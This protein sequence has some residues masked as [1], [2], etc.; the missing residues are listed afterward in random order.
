MRHVADI[1]GVPFAPILPEPPPPCAGCNGV[2]IP[3]I[4]HRV[5]LTPD[6]P[7]PEQ[8]LV[9][10]ESWKRFHTHWEHKLWTI[11]NLPPLRNQAIFDVSQNFSLQSDI[12]RYEILSIYGGVYLDTDMECLAAI[13]PLICGHSAFAG[14]EDD[15]HVGN[16]ILGCT[17]GHPFMQGMVDGLAQSIRE[18][19]GES[20]VETTGPRYLQRMAQGRTDISLFPARF[21]Y[22]LHAS[23]RLDPPASYPGAYAVHHWSHSWFG[24]PNL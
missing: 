24:L 21:F 14:W 17:A 6:R 11:N 16:A 20:P 5:W 3:K 1:L 23:K 4:F 8:Y 19:P 9:W 10:A 12:V 18:R 2:C 15:W 22:P 7:M 13:D